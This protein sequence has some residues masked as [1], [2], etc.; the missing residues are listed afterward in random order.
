MATRD[1][2]L[3]ILAGQD[4]ATLLMLAVEH[5][6]S[7]DQGAAEVAYHLSAVMAEPVVAERKPKMITA[8]QAVPGT[9]VYISVAQGGRNA[10]VREHAVTVGEWRPSASCG[11]G[12]ADLHDVHGKFWTVAAADDLLPIE[13]IGWGL[14]VSPLTY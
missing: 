9:T 8:R 13:P 11:T 7:L 10:G 1:Q 12:W 2:L 3:K 14:P 4:E 5:G 6:V